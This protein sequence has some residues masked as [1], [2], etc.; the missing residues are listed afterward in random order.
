MPQRLAWVLL[1][2]LVIAA[3]AEAQEEPDI[4][5]EGVVPPGDETHFFEEFEVPEGIVEVEVRHDDLSTANILDWGLDDPNGFR[6]WG[7]GNRE[8]AIVGR[9]ARSAAEETHGHDHGHAT[10]N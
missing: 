4:R 5:I 6:G 10:E 8:A 3:P 1:G 2:A 7:G 9:P